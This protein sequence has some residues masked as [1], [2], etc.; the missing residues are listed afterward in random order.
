MRNHGTLTKWNDDRGFGFITP[1]KGTADLFVH[2]S[3]FPRDS[4]RPRLNELISFEIETG[5]DGKQRAVRVMRSGQRLPSHPAR[6]REPRGPRSSRLRNVITLLAVAG[7]GAFGY[8]E[9]TKRVA[10]TN[11]LSSGI[12][13]PV[14]PASSP[15][16]CDGRTRCPQMSSC[17]EA[18]YFINHCPNTTM[19]GDGDGV[20]CE[21]QWCN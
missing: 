5:P 20:P 13:M 16:T 15:Y 10:P 12:S 9:Y 21:S 1:A 17:D 18:T 3:A 14:V 4:A 6:A 8:S 11:S 7:L 19:D 2:I